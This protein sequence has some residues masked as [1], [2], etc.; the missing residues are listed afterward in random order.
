MCLMLILPLQLNNIKP[1]T[2]QWEG[3]FKQW[4]CP[5]SVCCLS[6]CLSFTSL[7]DVTQYYVVV[8]NPRWRTVANMT[9]SCAEAKNQRDF[10]AV[11]FRFKVRQRHSLQVKV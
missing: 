5:L 2:T 7:A 9:E 1:R 6:V 10:E 3:D 8:T 11:F 4:Q